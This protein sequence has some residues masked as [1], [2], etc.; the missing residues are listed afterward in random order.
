MKKVVLIILILCN[1][2]LILAQNKQ[3]SLAGEYATESSILNLSVKRD[4]FCYFMPRYGAPGFYDT[5]ALGNLTKK[6]DDFIELNGENLLALAEK[7]TSVIQGY[8]PDLKDSVEF[9]FD[10]PITKAEITLSI[11]V[12]ASLADYNYYYLEK[13][14]RKNCSL[15]L[16]ADGVF[17]FHYSM[18]PVYTSNM[19]LFY[20]GVL[21]SL[22]YYAHYKNIGIEEGKNTITIKI[23]FI[24][25]RFF[26]KEFIVGEYAM[27]RGDTI[28]WRGMNFVKDRKFIPPY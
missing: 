12:N 19:S 16:P 20:D 9:I 11:E 28:Y 26:E 21:H 23:P 15:R 13:D 1:A 22:L 10:M 14:A 6:C 3:N 5:L 27:I 18:E 24:D 8:N 25:D 4:S 7:S 17:S 2:L